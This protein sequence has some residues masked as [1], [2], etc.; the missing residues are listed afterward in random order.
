[1]KKEQLSE[2]PIF[3]LRDEIMQSLR[4]GSF[5][6]SA[7]G[8]GTNERT[9]VAK[10]EKGNFVIRF[11]TLGGFQLKRGYAAQQ[12][13][14]QL[15]VKVP[16]TIAHNL[17]DQN[18]YGLWT[19]EERVDGVPFFTDRMAASE[20]KG[21]A[22]D[23]GKQLNIVHAS[24][25]DRF[26]LIPPYP[27]SSYEEWMKSDP[28]AVRRSENSTGPVFREFQ[29]S[30]DFKR[31]KIDSAFEIGRVDT[32][33]LPEGKEVYSQ[34]AYENDPRFCGGDTATSN[35]LVNDGKVS[36]I[37][38]WEWAHGGD[39]AE[40][41]AAWSYWNKDEQLLSNFLD[42]YKPENLAGFRK[43]VSLYEVMCAINLMHVYKG[44]GN[45]KGIEET[46]TILEKKLKDKSWK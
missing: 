38:D 14:E 23:L 3:K 33:Y 12:K 18:E 37:I 26:G 35:I 29:E 24:K 13:A 45:W 30:I 5:D 46:K 16:R 32:K 10:T 6:L 7:I 9:F 8:G 40:N 21:A 34:L 31:D 39:P 27:Y 4:V 28:E 2:N 15:G 1:M 20:A 11:E 43:R 22:L 36:A 42:G 41:V 25:V 19:A 44:T 17:D